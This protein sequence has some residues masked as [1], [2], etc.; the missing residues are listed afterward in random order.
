MSRTAV[1]DTLLEQAYAYCARLTAGKA[2]SFYFAARFLPSA[3]RRDVLAL[4]AFCRTVDDIADLPAQGASIEAIR[5]QLDDW[6]RWLHAG[7]PTQDDPIRYALAHAVRAYHLPLSPLLELLAAVDDDVEPRHL[8][9]LA[10]LERY[11]YGVAG[12]VGIVMAALLGAEASAWQPARDLGIAM[13]LTNVL[14]D[15]GEDLARGR[16]YLPAA[17]MARYGYARTDLERGV[18]DGRFV[19]LMRHSIARAH[20]YYARGLAGVGQ[21]PRESQVGIALAAHTYAGILTAIERADY[22]VF[23]Q[24]AR[25]SRWEKLQLVTRVRL[26]HLLTIPPWRVSAGA[27]RRGDVTGEKIP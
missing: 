10:A 18:V 8:S 24:R 26:E 23:T 15:V 22:D 25:T 2:R 9:D 16:I 14:R 6:R 5:R 3:T 11:C 19:A 20:H 17:E 1:A 21:L 7:A 27:T 4:Y 12:T 13:Q